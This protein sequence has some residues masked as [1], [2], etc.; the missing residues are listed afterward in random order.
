VDCLRVSDGALCLGVADDLV[1]EDAAV[2]KS[3]SGDTLHASLRK[4]FA[5][6][7]HLTLSKHHSSDE[8]TSDDE[9]DDRTARFSFGRS[10]SL[11]RLKR[12][13]AA[14]TDSPN[15]DGDPTDESTPSRISFRSLDSFLHAMR[16][17]DLSE[18]TSEDGARVSFDL[19]FKR[20]MERE[21]EKSRRMERE[22]LLTT[23]A[24]SSFHVFVRSDQGEV[25]E[26]L[27]EEVRTKLQ[28]I[29]RLVLCFPSFVTGGC[30]GSAICWGIGGT[31]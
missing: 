23:R 1:H 12:S 15:N 24:A 20:R 31:I 30:R 27:E 16:S 3:A 13:P 29:T 10:L 21:V 28:A 4:K 5:S 7:S 25:I 26:A 11:F 19:L 2:V 14:S 8:A 6:F 17:S 9:D 18:R 22:H